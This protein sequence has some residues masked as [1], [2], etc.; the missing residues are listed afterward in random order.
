MRA[1]SE[2][3][4]AAN[5]PAGIWARAEPAASA[6]TVSAARARRMRREAVGRMS[7]VA[8]SGGRSGGGGGQ[9]SL[10]GVGTGSKRGWL[11]GRL[12]GWL[13]GRGLP[14]VTL[15]YK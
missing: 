8:E 4:R 9:P 12:G 10:E 3:R 5:S 2:S 11:G 6:V 14:V 7:G 13:N 1:A 15:M